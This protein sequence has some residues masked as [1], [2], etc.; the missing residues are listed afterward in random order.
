MSKD[1][2]VLA[3]VK[4]VERYIFLYDDESRAETLRILGRYAL[5]PELSFNWYDA[6]TLSQTIRQKEQKPIFSTVFFNP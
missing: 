5:N 4:G 6:A 1:I 2:N 3:L